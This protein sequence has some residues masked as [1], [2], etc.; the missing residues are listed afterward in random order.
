MRT[1]SLDPATQTGWCF[2]G[3][4]S[5]QDKDLEFGIFRMPK[6]PNMGE[7]FVIFGDTLSELIAHYAPIQMIAFEL[8]YDPP[9]PNP[10]HPPRIPYN[11]E[12]DNFLQ[13]V[14]AILLYIAAKHSIPVEGYRSQSWRITAL[15]MGRAPKGAPAGEMKR[16][17]IR[18]AKSLGFNVQTEDEADAIGVWLHAMHGD[19]ANKRAQ[20]DLLDNKGA[21]L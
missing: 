21:A 5:L 12:T 14:K 2:G 18:K 6:R 10:K 7:R 3:D 16:M 4:N 15:G 13:G 11:R 1:L 8:P 20:T 17:M 19:P 9:P